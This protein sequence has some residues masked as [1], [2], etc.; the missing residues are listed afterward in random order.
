MNRP[1]SETGWPGHPDPD[2]VWIDRVRSVYAIIDRLRADLP[3][4]DYA[5]ILVHLIREPAEASVARV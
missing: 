3:P 4:G 5:S 2:R 1:F